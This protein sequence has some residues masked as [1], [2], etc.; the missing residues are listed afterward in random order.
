MLWPCSAQAELPAGRWDP[1]WC[2]APPEPCRRKKKADT[3]RRQQ[4]EGREEDLVRPPHP[5]RGDARAEM[6]E[7]SSGSSTRA[8]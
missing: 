8:P 7:Q 6:R 4:W 5:T 3:A 1:G 2:L